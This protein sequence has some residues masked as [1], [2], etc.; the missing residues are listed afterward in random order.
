MSNENHSIAELKFVLINTNI[1]NRKAAQNDRTP[2]GT[3]CLNN[4]IIKVN[5]TVEYI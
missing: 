4:A 5:K 3:Y 2:K 1:Y